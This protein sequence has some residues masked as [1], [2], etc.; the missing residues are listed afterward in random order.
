MMKC[1][2][3][4]FKVLAGVALMWMLSISGN[5]VGATLVTDIRGQLLG[6]DGIDI[7]GATYNVDFV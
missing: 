2:L 4:S 1:P 3:A 5:A 7:N 6:V